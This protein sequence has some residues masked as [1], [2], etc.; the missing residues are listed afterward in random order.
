MP[1]SG[2]EGAMGRQ[3]LI[4]TGLAVL[5]FALGMGLTV[6]R[7]LGLSLQFM[8]G[9]PC[10][11]RFSSFILEH[12]YLF[13]TGRVP[14]YWSAPF[15]YPL[16]GTVSFSD[17]FLATL[18]LYAL[19]RPLVPDRETAYQLW[20][21]GLFALNY[22]LCRYGARRLGLSPFPATLVA[23]VCAFSLPIMEEVAHPAML[24]LFMVPIVYAYTALFFSEQKI[25]HLY[26]AGL[27][28]VVQFYCSFYVAVLLGLS[29]VVFGVVRCVQ[30]R[31]V[32]REV[33][34]SRRIV[35]VLAL[36]LLMAGLLAPLVTPYLKTAAQYGFRRF[37]EGVI[38]QLPQAAYYL[39]ASRL[40]LPWGFTAALT[41][42]GDVANKLFPGLLPVS[43]FLLFPFLAGRGDAPFRRL[44]WALWLV[45]V[46]LVAVTLRVGDR[47]AYTLLMLVPPFDSL[48]ALTRIGLLLLFPLAMLLGIV[49]TRLRQ[50]LPRGLPA[51]LVGLVLAGAVVLDQVH[52]REYGYDK[53]ET[54]RQVAALTD[55]LRRAGRE[56]AAFV[57][58]PAEADAA[59]DCG[60]QVNALLAAQDLGV[61]TVNAYTSWFPPGYDLFADCGFNALQKWVYWSWFYRDSAVD[62]ARAFDDLLV[63]SDAGAVPSDLYLGWDGLREHLLARYFADPAGQAGLLHFIL[64]MR[65]FYQTP[66]D[67]PWMGPWGELATGANERFTVTFVSPLPTTLTLWRDGRVERTVAVRPQEPLVISGGGEQAARYRLESSRVYTGSR[68]DPRPR[69][70]PVSLKVTAL[71][72]SRDAPAAGPPDSKP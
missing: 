51:G 16:A 67:L 27:A 5:L 45:V 23:Y 66:A 50:R 24:H 43:A 47:S 46:F 12:G 55:R 30:Y 3:R 65:G 20:F 52:V 69:H 21:A 11:S 7:M 6:W 72:F 61:A 18:P 68:H 17:N 35:P 33:V 31:T 22:W 29:L 58:I 37:P 63:V 54:Q 10:D 1:D 4:E 40:S 41:P 48:R 9:E 53:A 32:V 14:S 42:E 19:I 59:Y 62:P 25:S 64:G 44:G 70:Y 13:L 71:E 60:L 49:L 56:F 38:E 39:S 26:V 8:P 34:C 28:L 57:H 2:R 15:L 36:A